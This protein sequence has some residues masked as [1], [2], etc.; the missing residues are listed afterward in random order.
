MDCTKAPKNQ[1]QRKKGCS[2]VAK[3]QARWKIFKTSGGQ[4]FLVGV[5]CPPLIRIGL[6]NVQA[7]IDFR[8][9]DFRNFQFNAVYDS[10]LFSSP[11]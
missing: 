5:I 7:F 9:F 6:K 4:G 10:I 3:L 8:G 11:L 1:K 2:R